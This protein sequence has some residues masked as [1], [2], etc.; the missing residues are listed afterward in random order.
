MLIFEIFRSVSFDRRH[1]L[2]FRFLG[3]AIDSPSPPSRYGEFFTLAQILITRTAWRLLLW[4]KAHAAHEV[5][6][7]EL[8]FNWLSMKTIMCCPPPSPFSLSPYLIRAPLKALSLDTFACVFIFHFFRV[9]LTRPIDLRLT[10]QTL[11]HT[12]AHTYT[13]T[14]AAI[15]SLC[16][17]S[18]LRLTVSH[19][20]CTQ[21]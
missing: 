8:D 19:C 4:H 7:F 20:P 11:A 2:S 17:A 9:S 10:Q 18:Q 21:V 6:S 16:L 12:Q 5:E 3:Y 13:H 14:H 15:Q 1:C